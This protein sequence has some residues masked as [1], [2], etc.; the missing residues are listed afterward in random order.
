MKNI[1]QSDYWTDVRG[2]E[3]RR[4]TELWNASQDP[5]GTGVVPRPAYASMFA[6]P[7][8]P[9]ATQS[10]QTVLTMAGTQVKR[11]EFTHNNM[12]PFFRGSMRQNMDPLAHATTLEKFTGSAS[13]VPFQHKKEV[14][15]LFEPT[16]GFTNIYGM[17]NSSDFYNQHIEAPRARNNDFPIE[18][19]RV[20][21][22]LGQGFTATPEG[23]FQQSNTLDYIRPKN[24]D[25]LRVATKPK[26]SYQIPFQGPQKGIEK[27]GMVGI[28]EKN[29]TDTFFEQTPDMP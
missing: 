28:V 22:G 7:E 19:V 24:V 13:S 11:E 27:R 2:D 15:C 29:R 4:G 5:F 23:G 12:M 9:A 1:Y 18:P 21:R 6:A 8:A 26:L 10:D 20:G 14:Q 17:Q 16:P 25:E 3:M